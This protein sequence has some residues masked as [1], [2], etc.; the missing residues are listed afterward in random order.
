M[1]F[2]FL[3]FNWSECVVMFGTSKCFL[4]YNLNSLLFSLNLPGSLSIKMGIF[5]SIQKVILLLRFLLII[6]RNLKRTEVYS[7]RWDTRTAK[8]SEFSLFSLF[9]GELVSEVNCSWMVLVL[10]FWFFASLSVSFFFFS[11]SVC[12]PSWHVSYKQL[13]IMVMTEE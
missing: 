5:V 2:N 11:V 13:N 3:L 12:F 8:K 1:F 9:F 6:A 10:S 4:H 7:S